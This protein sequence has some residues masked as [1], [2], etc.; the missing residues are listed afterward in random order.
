MSNTAV[1]LPAG[2]Y[3]QMVGWRRHLHRNPEISYREFETTAFIIEKLSPLGFKIERPLETGLVAVLEG[4]KPGGTVALRADIDA[5]PMQEYGEAKVAFISQRAGAAHCCGH[6]LHTA[7][8]LGAAH[9][10]A[11]MRHEITG[12]IVLVFQPGEEKLPGGARLLMENGILE[13]LGVQAIFGLHSDPWHDTGVLSL[14]SGP[15]MARPDEFELDIIGY[16]G[17]AAKPHEA[18]D[19][20]VMGAHF[21]SMVQTVVSRHINPV[22]PR[23]VTVGQF[24]GGSTYNVIPEKVF[25]KGTVRTFSKETAGKIFERIEAIARGVTS[26]AGGSFELRINQGY[27]AVINPPTLAAYAKKIAA[28]VAGAQNVVDLKE[29]IMAGE[30]FGF[31]Q[32]KIPGVFLFLGTG[33]KEADSCYPWHHPKYNTDERAMITG[34]GLLC[35]FALGD[36]KNF[37]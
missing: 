24:T 16:G 22:E 8:L 6:D 18:V 26:A 36:Y 1:A 5:L 32:E 7:T 17:H 12:R 29:P 37:L 15:M 13:R 27:P 4:G 33:S 35:N 31:Y 20:I 25:I 2:L 30:D 14:K 11:G 34:A 23:V 19:P 28:E 9:L 10:L 3:E 21:V